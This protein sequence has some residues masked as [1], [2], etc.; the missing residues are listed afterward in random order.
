MIHVQKARSERRDL[1]HALA[2]SQPT[3][4]LCNRNHITPAWTDTSKPVTCANCRRAID[5]VIRTQVSNLSFAGMEKVLDL[6]TAMRNGD[7][8][9]HRT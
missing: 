1:V 5:Q 4:S 8:V 6:I 9:E 7:I 2:P 3:L